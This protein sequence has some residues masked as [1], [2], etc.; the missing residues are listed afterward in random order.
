MYNVQIISIVANVVLGITVL[1]LISPK[2][3][4]SYKDY[5][6]QRE[7]RRDKV[8]Q[9]NNARLV[10]TIRTEVRRYLEELKQ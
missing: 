5:K 3:I 4:Q 7:T 10:K 8:R 1:S 9:A 6:K 2:M